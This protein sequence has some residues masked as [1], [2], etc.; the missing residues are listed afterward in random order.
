MRLLLLS[1]SVLVLLCSAFTSQPSNAENPKQLTNSIGMKLVL[2]PN[3][4]FTMGS[5]IGEE[6]RNDDESQHEVV[7]SKDFYLGAFEVTQAEYLK[8]M[9]KNP[10]PFKGDIAGSKSQ[11]L[12]VD[13]VSWDDAVEFC[14][15][16]SER[17]EEKK[18]GRVYRLPTEA[19]WEYA[20]RAGSK[21]AFHFDTNSKTIDDYAWYKGNSKGQT[22][23][24]GG[25]SPN[26]WGLYDMHG[27]VLE[28]CSDWY[29]EYPKGSVTDPA[30]ML[31][32]GTY[33]IC[34]GGGL[35]SFAADCRS[36]IRS[37]SMPSARDFF[38]GLRVVMTVSGNAN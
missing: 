19:E 27:N 38:N 36:A 10:S 26:D 17:P 18:A 31:E 22:H 28:W 11:D 35:T 20:C 2:I 37:R 1:I 33:R 3:G 8:V 16:L 6:E 12:P 30:G 15:R 9:G 34:R 4:S 7:I 13:R 32:G 25:K 23:A 21:T 14:K 29:G 5:P 24:V